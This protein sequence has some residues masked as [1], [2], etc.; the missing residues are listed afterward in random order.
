MDRT[1]G[2][3]A[4]TARLLGTNRNRIYRVLEQDKDGAGS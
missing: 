1:G 4:E 3:I 2:N